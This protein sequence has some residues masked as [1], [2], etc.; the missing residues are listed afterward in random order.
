MT[1]GLPAPRI[2]PFL[3]HA[4]SRSRYGG[5]AE[6]EISRL[7]LIGNSG[8]YLDS[9]YHRHRE[10]ADIAGLPLEALVG[11]QGVCLD[12]RVSRS[13]AVDADLATEAMTGRA[14][15][16]RTGWDAR[17]GSESYWR[18][19]PFLADSLIGRLVDGGAA[20]VGVDFANVDDVDD[21]ARPVH[22]RLLGAEIPIVEH[23][24]GLDRLPRIGFRFFAPV[25]AIRGAAA[26]P[27]RAFAE[28]DDALGT[29]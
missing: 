28:L 18:N 13:R 19:G 3:S 16:V 2:E 8:T 26:L 17:F 6:F 21:P 9:P 27:V 11:L 7:F 5:R 10:L 4:A 1:P 29:I 23:L 14:V 12:G 25:L 22:T 24:V 15:L 20:L